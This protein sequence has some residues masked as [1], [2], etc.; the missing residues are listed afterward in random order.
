MSFI[1]NIKN[2]INSWENP[3]LS[4]FRLVSFGFRSVYFENVASIVSYTKE[5]IVLGLKKGALKI[6]GKELCIKKY[7]GGDVVVCGEI[8]K[9]ERV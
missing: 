6:E 2:C 3:N 7:C 9:I 8:K 4:E 5:Q 1:D